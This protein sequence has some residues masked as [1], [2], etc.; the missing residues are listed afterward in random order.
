M[1]WEPMTKSVIVNFNDCVNA[2]RDLQEI[3][4]PLRPVKQT[5]CEAAFDEVIGAVCIAAGVT[6]QKVAFLEQGN[7]VGGNRTGQMIRWFQNEM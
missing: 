6:E 1:R 2:F 4:C 3:V 5:E 7:V